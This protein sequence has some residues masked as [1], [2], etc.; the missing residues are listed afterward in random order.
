MKKLA[1][2]ITLALMVSMLAVTATAEGTAYTQAPMLDAMVESGEIPPLEERLPENP[3]VIKEIL[4][5]YL[6][7]EVG[8]YGGTLRLVT[9]SVNWDADGFVAMTEGLLTMESS[10]SDVVSPNIVE[11]YEVSDDNKVFT[12]HLRKG[13]K[14]SDGEEVTMEDFE[15]GINDFIM[16]S[17]LTPVIAAYMRD[18]GTASGDPFTFEVI[19]DSTFTITFKESYGGFIVH[20]SIAGWKGYT[21]FLKPAHFLKPYHKD[22]AEECHGSLEAYYEFMQPYATVMGYDDVT[23][24]G[25]WCY[26]FNQMDCTNWECTDP[27]DTMPSYYFGDIAP[28]SFP[29]LYPWIM[30]GVS[31]T[32][33]TWT[34]NPYYWCVDAAGQQL[35]Y[36]DTITSKYVESSELVQFSAMA[37]E[38]DFMR[39]SATINNISLYRENDEKANITAYTTDLHNNPG[40]LNI[41]FNYGLNTDGS[42]KEGDEFAAWQE[43]VNDKRFLQAL[44][45]SIDANE[46]VDAVF[47]GFAEPNE[48]FACD[49]DQELAISLLDEMGAVD[50]DGDGWRETPS[51]LPF[52]F[53]IYVS[54]SGSLTDVLSCCELYFEYWTEIGLNVQVMPTDGTLL[55]TSRLA[56]E[57]TI[58]ANWLHSNALWHYQEWYYN[59]PLWQDWID[60]GG[61]SGELKGTDV[62]LEPS[63][64]FK[65]F[66]LGIQ[67]CFTVDP[68]TAV[69]ENVPNLVKL[70]AENLWD[71]EPLQHVQQCVVINTD[72]R[73]IPTGGIGISWNFA[74]E[75]MFYENPDQH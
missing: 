64:E 21:E 13:L 11:A 4:D 67:G 36:F 60:A 19:D 74:L 23:E 50:I 30:T 62:L 35:P 61:L 63:E 44:M 43:M 8:N 27:N 41:N 28:T 15:F 75:Q 6:D 3:C 10:N 2:L 29:Q 25:V 53:T 49:G 73:N 71:I 38:V 18:A 51:G 65:E 5:E 66:V 58:L 68:V 1:W 40:D 32:L 69:N 34:R 52:Y 59:E 45:H 47:N 7:Q 57:L 17:E 72:M 42:I 26:I 33:T 37:G 70:Q 24:D 48:Y 16:N 20:L 54:S 12:F 55:D 39:E 14:W 22:Y 56:N 31:D 46:L 9:S